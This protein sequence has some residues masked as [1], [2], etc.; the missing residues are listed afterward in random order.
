VI[1][2]SEKRNVVKTFD[3]LTVNEGLSKR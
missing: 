3:V 2:S 1:F